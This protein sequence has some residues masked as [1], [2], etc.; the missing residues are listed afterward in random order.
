M[1]PLA[2]K[3]GEI[4]Q[5]IFHDYDPFDP[6]TPNLI[7]NTM[8]CH[9]TGMLSAGNIHIARGGTMQIHNSQLCKSYGGMESGGDMEWLGKIALSEE[10]Q[11]M[12]V[13]FGL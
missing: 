13:S 11:G 6:I 8:D 9:W 10:L 2:P 12:P 1:G 4:I 3:T 5:Q 7:Q